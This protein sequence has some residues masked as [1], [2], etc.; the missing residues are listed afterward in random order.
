MLTK[1]VHKIALKLPC[2]RMYS[3]W[4]VA[5]DRLVKIR[6][7]RILCGG[8]AISKYTAQYFAFVAEFCEEARA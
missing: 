7:E 3:E 2:G 6:Y 1:A 8:C 5:R 4:G